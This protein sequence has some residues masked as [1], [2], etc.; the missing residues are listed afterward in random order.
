MVKGLVPNY[1]YELLPQQVNQ[2]S[3]YRLRNSSNYR[4][5]K[6]RIVRFHKSF[7]PSST[8]AWNALDP[9]LRNYDT[10][11]GFKMALKKVFFL[12]K[13]TG[14]CFIH[15]ARIRMGLSG[16]N[17]HRKKYHFIHHSNCAF[18]NDRVEDAIHFFSSADIMLP[19]VRSCSE[20]SHQSSH[21]MLILI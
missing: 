18:C 11:S 2:I 8:R 17:Q 14:C 19:S 15:Q 20:V 4:A 3:N 9:N 1:L 10:L 21:Q 6:S 12:L 13:I 7:L 16:L 5:P